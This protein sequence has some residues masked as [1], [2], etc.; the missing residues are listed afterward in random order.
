MASLRKNPRSPYWIACFSLPDGRRTN[1]STSV[2][3]VPRNR[4]AAQKIADKYEEAARGKVTETQARKVI[5]DIYEILHGSTLPSATV[6]A[7]LGEWGDNLGIRGVGEST[8]RAYRQASRDFLTFLGE[9]RGTDIAQISRQEI[10]RFRDHVAKRTTASTANKQLKYLR[11]AF[12]KARQ[13]GLIPTSPA[14]DVPIIRIRGDAQT[15]R[16]PFTLDELTRILALSSDEWRGIVLFGFYTGQR[17]G[18]IVRLTWEG[19]DLVRGEFRFVTRKTGR[20][21][22]LPIAKPLASYLAALPA[23]D[24]AD[25]P[26]FP[27]AFEVAIGHTSLST[28]SQQFYAILR[29]A[30]LV[31]VDRTK[32]PKDRLGSGR[33]RARQVNAISFHSLRHTATSLLK[34]AGVAEAVARDIIG[35]ESEAI[36]RE[37]THIEADVKRAALD[38][39]P[40]IP[41]QPAP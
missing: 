34:S 8:A 1:R 30:G 22:A 31:D 32:G 15:E 21:M 6:D 12:N 7:F 10:S 3:A 26:L 17:L 41:T 20:R 33:R 23:R 18:D 40:T 2:E 16:R 36:S 37:Y 13:D 4:K 28:L 19:V 25:A 39:L 27:K 29:S 35:H 11:V 14:A 24:A 5:G 9:R 38:K